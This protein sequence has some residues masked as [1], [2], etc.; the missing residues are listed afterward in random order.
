VRILLDNNIPYRFKRALVDLDVTHVQDVGLDNLLDGPL[1]AAINGRFEL[2]V[3]MDRS[4]RH[5][6]NLTARQFAVVVLRAK[7]NRIADILPLVPALRQQMPH[8]TPSNWYEVG[9]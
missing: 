6:Q 9:P 5:Q 1:L 4:L 2:L 7:S 8:C 3:T